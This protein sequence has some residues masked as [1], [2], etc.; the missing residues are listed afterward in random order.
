MRHTKIQK[1]GFT[2][3]KKK[4]GC[5]GCF[6]TVVVAGLVLALIGS[7]SGSDKKSTEEKAEV[8]TEVITKEATK[9]KK[10]EAKKENTEKK[11]VKKEKKE[12]KSDTECEYGDTILKYRE[13]KIAKDDLDNDVLILYFDFINNSDENKSYLYTYTTKVFQNGVELEESMIHAGQETRNASLEIQP[14]ASVVV[15]DSYNFSGDESTATVEVEP[16]VSFSD[17]KLM[18]FDLTF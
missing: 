12:V 10:T 5:L 3:Q 6:G 1:G 4:S 8:A 9:E 15:A 13:C 2:M 16:W 14:G 17:D 11:K 18:K 7:F